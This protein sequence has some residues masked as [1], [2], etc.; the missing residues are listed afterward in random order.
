MSEKANGRDPIEQYESSSTKTHTPLQRERL[1]PTVKEIPS[2]KHYD[3]CTADEFSSDLAASQS[4]ECRPVNT[5]SK[6]VNGGAR[7]H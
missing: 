7:V 4:R 6:N 5:A 3:N 2:Y 1:S